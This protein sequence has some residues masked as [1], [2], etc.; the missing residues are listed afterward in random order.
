[1]NKQE[2]ID[3]INKHDNFYLAT[4]DNNVPSVR[5]MKACIVDERGIIFNTKK[6]KNSYRQL[7]NNPKVEMCFYDD[8]EEIQI[9]ISGE[10]EILDDLSI[11][12]DIKFFN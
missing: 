7:K 9:R 6:F 3:F 10:V 11:K 2:I 4:S 1:M 5:V 12:K 8:K